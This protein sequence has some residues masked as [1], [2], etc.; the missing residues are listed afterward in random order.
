M[1]LIEYFR[2]LEAI[3][4]SPWLNKYKK[5]FSPKELESEMFDIMIQAQNNKKYYNKE[6]AILSNDIIEK[7]I[8]ENK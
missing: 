7:E 4:F 6:L 2:K 8:E 5:L 3:S 1:K